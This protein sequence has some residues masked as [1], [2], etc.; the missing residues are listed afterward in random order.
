[1]R[2]QIARDV[3]GP[4]AE[5]ADPAAAGEACGQFVEDSPVERLVVELVGEALGVDVG[6]R[7]VA[8]YELVAGPGHV[9][10][11]ARHAPPDPTWRKAGPGDSIDY[12]AQ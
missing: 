4:A 9:S 3:A 8:G 5:V 12:V 6:H 11:V 1:L 2:A 7:V 10:I